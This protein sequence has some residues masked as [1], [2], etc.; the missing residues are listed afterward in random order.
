[1]R[2]ERFCSGSS[3]YVEA[4]QGGIFLLD[5]SPLAFVSES[6]G[7]HK[8]RKRSGKEKDFSQSLDTRPIFLTRKVC[9][10][11]MWDEQ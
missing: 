9:E 1:M 10:R 4:V 5:L 2:K 6:Q 8:K 3:R 11:E 7:H